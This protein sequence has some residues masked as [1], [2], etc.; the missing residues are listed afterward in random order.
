MDQNN[1]NLHYAVPVVTTDGHVVM[2]SDQG[3][4]T[5][6]FFQGREQHD[7]HLHADVVAGVRLNNLEDLENLSKAIKETIKKH[8][9][10][11]P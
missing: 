6:L 4:P 1:L 8:K 2:L 9:D 3:V 7:G 11:E 10:R 5:I